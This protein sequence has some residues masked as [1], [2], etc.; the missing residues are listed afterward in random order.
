[1]F[2]IKTFA[3]RFK[4]NIV[5]AKLT[6]LEH[7]LLNRESLSKLKPVASHKTSICQTRKR[8][9]NSDRGVVCNHTLEYNLYYKVGFWEV[10]ASHIL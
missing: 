6:T 5:V 1:M 4:V 3:I 2:N 10:I 7:Y 8:K 9:I